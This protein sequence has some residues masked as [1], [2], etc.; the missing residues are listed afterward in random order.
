ML[1]SS[2]M[3]IDEALNITLKDIELDESPVK[4]NISGSITKTGNSRIAFFSHEAKEAIQ[5]WLKERRTYLVNAAK[6]S[7]YGKIW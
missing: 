3:R 7:R 6:K 2:G 1:A 5:E 4:I